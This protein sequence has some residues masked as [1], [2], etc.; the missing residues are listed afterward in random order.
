MV[1]SP[2][3]VS[4]LSPLSHFLGGFSGVSTRRNWAF[5]LFL[6][7]L[8]VTFWVLAGG[9]FLA[10]VGYVETSEIIML[11]NYI[12]SVMKAGGV[13]GCITSVIA[14]TCGFILLMTAEKKFEADQLWLPLGPALC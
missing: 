6:L 13:L 14:Y 10:S 8:A 9:A 7:F 5:F 4:I 3:E 11:L 12:Y 2:F 1:R